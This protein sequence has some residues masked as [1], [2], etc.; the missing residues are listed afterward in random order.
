MVRVKVDPF[1]VSTYCSDLL[2][3]SLNANLANRKQLEGGVEFKF[4]LCNLNELYSPHC[5]PLYMD[6]FIQNTTRCVRQYKIVP[7]A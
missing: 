4:S 6:T 5:T 1:F 3:E 7:L 2:G